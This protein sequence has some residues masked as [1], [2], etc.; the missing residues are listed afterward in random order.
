L[1]AFRQ[2]LK[3]TGHIEGQTVAIEYRWAENQIDRLSALAAD[4]ARRQVAAIVPAAQPATFAAKAATTTI[5]IVFLLS[6]DPVKLGLVASVARPGG[7]LTGVNFLN[8]ELTQKRLELLHE[9]VSG[10]A[11]VAV[12][13]NPANPNTETTVKDVE[14]RRAP[15]G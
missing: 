10:A 6:D 4:L 2:A 1:R 9:L 12:L 15:W 13:V 11:R 5:P 14:Q 3:E 7:N 8:V